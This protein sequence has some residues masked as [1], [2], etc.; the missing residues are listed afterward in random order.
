[1]HKISL[2]EFLNRNPKIKKLNKANQTQNYNL[3][4]QERQNNIKKCIEKRKEIILNTNTKNQIQ[5]QQQNNKTNNTKNNNTKNNNTNNT[6]S[7]KNIRPR[8]IEIEKNDKNSNSKQS[9]DLVKKKSNIFEE[10]N[11]IFMTDDTY[12]MRKSNGR[13]SLITKDDLDQITCLKKDKCFFEQKMEEKEDYLKHLLRSEIILEKRIRKVS[14]KINKR[15]KKINGFLNDKKDCIKFI[16]KEKFQDIIDMHKRKVLYEKIASNYNK[17]INISRIKNS[18]TQEKMEELKEQIKD[19]E[20][21]N[22]QY[23][24]KISKMFDKTENEDKLINEAKKIDKNN[25]AQMK[26]LEKKEQFELNRFKR[27][28]ALMNHIN[29][30]QDKINGFLE[31]NDKREKKIIQAIGEVEKKREEKKNLQN[32]YLEGIKNKVKKN[33]KKLE[34]ERQK[35]IEYYE[36]K[37]LKDFAIKQEKIKLNEINKIMNQLDKKGRDEMKNNL[38]K[39][40]R[41]K[42]NLNQIEKDENFI[43]NLL[44]N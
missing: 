33:E 10:K 6:K 21:K 17:K 28:N 38:R 32:M 13:E 25:Y 11:R 37:D 39:I 26:V 34:K 9:R 16:K 7:N 41:S 29:R 8:N 1:M 22:K 40:I 31:E 20:K 4:E 23:K 19:Y 2:Q 5:N 24:Q 44:N 27:E 30:V 43:D 14:E 42:K 36:D 15:D 3:Y 35:K 18:Q 12:M